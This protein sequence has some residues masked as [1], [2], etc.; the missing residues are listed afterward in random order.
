[1]GLFEHFPYT[2]YHELNL[3]WIIE[4]IKEFGESV[5]LSV[6][7][8]TGEVVLYQ[9][10]DVEFPSVNDPSWQIFR[11]T[12]GKK[13]GV[14]FAN[15][16]MYFVDGN[17]ISQVYTSTDTPPYPVTSVN[18]ATGAVT[19]YPE[20]GIRFPDVT[21]AYMNMRR[22]IESNGQNV[23][24]GLEVSEN[25]ATRIKGTQRLDIYDAD[26]PPPYPV[27]SVNGSTGA[28]MLAIPFDTPLT[29]SIWTALN[30]SLTHDAGV[31]RDTV[32]G[33]ASVY[34]T[35]DSSHV[36]AYVK[37]VSS[38]QQ[39]TYTKKLLTTDDIPSS[40]GVVSVNGYNGVVVLHGTDINLNAFSNVDLNTAV[41]TLDESMA[42]VIRGNQS[43]S[44]VA[45]GQ[46]VVVVDSTITGVYDGLYTA[47]NSKA[48]GSTFVAADLTQVTNGGFNSLNDAIANVNMN[49]RGFNV[50]GNSLANVES[51]LDTLFSNMSDNDIRVGILFGS[52]S[53][54]MTGGARTS[55]IAYRIGNGTYK[56]EVLGTWKEGYYYS[57][58]WHWA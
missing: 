43:V 39:T 7:G 44:N 49:I 27:T 56:I 34:L 40:S 2:N 12:N 46:Y 51:A 16:H 25:K 35:T 21:D 31:E 42:I 18:G 36:E 1:M 32:D 55:A 54:S 11:M 41:T 24:V 3:D 50:S 14:Y 52:Y 20:A 5:V 38:D 9:D 29:A 26:N 10:N 47:V 58:A 57:G 17:V 37:F 15:D 23:I 4:K 53:G 33:T 13:V 30:A 19:L 48:A 45:A 22:Q 8:Q 28:V 6:N